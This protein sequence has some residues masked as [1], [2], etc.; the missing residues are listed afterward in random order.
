[1]KA[2]PVLIFAAVAAHG[3]MVRRVDSQPDG[4]IPNGYV[5]V[6][7]SNGNLTFGADWRLGTCDIGYRYFSTGIYR[8][9]VRH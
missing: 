7:V 8:E 9:G 6:L 4:S 2:I 1:M 3:E 5:P